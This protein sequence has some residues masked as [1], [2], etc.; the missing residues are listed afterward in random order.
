M[1]LNRAQNTM[2]LFFFDVNTGGRREVMTET[3]KTWLD[4]YDFYAGIEDLMTF[5][6]NSRE[7]FWISD[8]DG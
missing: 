4:V 1:T 8:R 3:S 6:E 2:K 5:P 7:F